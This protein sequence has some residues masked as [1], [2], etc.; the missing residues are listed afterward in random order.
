MPIELRNI[1]GRPEPQGFSHVS[2]A[3]GTRIVHIAGQ[4][5][6]DEEGAVVPGGLG[7]QAERAML[8]VGLALDTAGVAESDLAKLTVYVVDWEPSKFGDLGRGLLAVRE[9]RP[10]PSVPV[11]LIGVSALF[12]PEMLVEIEA[13]AVA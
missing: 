5:G 10:F 8:N 1:D 6:T 12:E 7:A 13:V 3:E 2:I 9:A 4:V 11:T